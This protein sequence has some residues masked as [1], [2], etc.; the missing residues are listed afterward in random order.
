[1]T[2]PQYVRA[3]ISRNLILHRAFR[4]RDPNKW[5]YGCRADIARPEEDTFRVEIINA[6]PVLPKT[7]LT[8]CNRC[9]G[10]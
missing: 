5:T 6:I 2:Q 4:R 8:Y 7:A 3:M 9:F 1:M 10:G